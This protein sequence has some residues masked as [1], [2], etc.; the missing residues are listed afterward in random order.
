MDKVGLAMRSC[1]PG[2]PNIL[3]PMRGLDIYRPLHYIPSKKSKKSMN[4]MGK[5][6]TTYAG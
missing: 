5:E 1:I 4:V 3:S 6:K 2:Y